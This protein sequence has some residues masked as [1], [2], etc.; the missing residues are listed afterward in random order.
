MASLPRTEPITQVAA[1]S[2]TIP[3]GSFQSKGF[4]G[5]QFKGM[6]NGVNIVMTI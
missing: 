5:F 2:M 3:G 1:F 4:G 6:V